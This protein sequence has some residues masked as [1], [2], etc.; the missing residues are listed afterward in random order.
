M[1]GGYDIVGDDILDD[2][3]EG[4][5]GYE[6][7]DLLIGED[8]DDDYEDEDIISGAG[9]T[10]IVGARARRRRKSRRSGRRTEFR[11]IVRKS[12]AAVIK[13]NLDKRRRYPLGVALTVLPPSGS[14]IVPTNPQNLFRAE[15]FVVPSDIGFDTQVSDVKVGNQSQFTA[16]IEVP[17]AV[18]SEVA[19]DTGL[20]FDTAEVGN[21]ITVAVRNTTAVQYDFKAAFIGTVAK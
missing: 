15:R 8:D 11:R 10:E 17:A 7:L 1:S 21:Q 9:D 18:F 6:D 20:S 12:A 14:I 13:R 2:E 4:S 3:D 16:G 5:I 19:V